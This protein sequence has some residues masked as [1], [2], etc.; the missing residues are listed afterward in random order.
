MP[1]SD[2]TTSTSTIPPSTTSTTTNK[3]DA[4]SR[5]PTSTSS[6]RGSLAGWTTCPL[7]PSKSSKRYALGRGIGAHLHAVHTPWKL[8][9]SELKRREKERMAARKRREN[10]D[11]RST[12]KIAR[13]RK[14]EAGDDQQAEQD[15][16][17]SK[18]GQTMHEECDSAIDA[19]PTSWT[20]TEEEMEAWGRRVAELTAQVEE[21]ASAAVVDADAADSTEPP[22]NKRRRMGDDNSSRY[23]PPGRDRTGANAVSS[24]RKSLP[25]LLAAAADGNAENIQILM[26]EEAKNSSSSVAEKN[27]RIRKLLDQQDRNGSIAE[28]WAAGGGHVDCLRLLHKYR[29]VVTASDNE[30]QDD[31][32]DNDDSAP[33]SNQ[34]QRRRDGRTSLHF[35][36]KNGQDDVVAYLLKERGSSAN[37]EVDVPTGDGTMPLHLACFSAH[38]STVKLLIERYGADVNRKNDWG[39]GVAHWIAMSVN[40]KREDV[41]HICQ[42][43]RTEHNIFFHDRQKQGHSAV[44]KAAQKKNR[45]VIEWC[46]SCMNSTEKEEAGRPDDG[47][48]KPSD[49]WASAGG[50][51]KFAEWMLSNGW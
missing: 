4:Y 42:Y 45:E 51:D 39:C 5:L 24:Y 27:N 23:V 7:C 22:P 17:I 34:R 3:G 16:E 31:D 9:K 44:H 12:K 8:G 40:P 2:T 35:A 33:T 32:D 47:G 15:V 46:D 1:P 43:L 41:V 6:G 50:D 14:R 18:Q 48:N 37:A 19:L 20:P 36:C 13:K 49:I 30:K 10:L 28:H 38:L 21:E 26:E 29:D 25:P 11:K